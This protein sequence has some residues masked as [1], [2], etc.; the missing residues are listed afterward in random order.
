MILHVDMDAFYASIEQLDDPSLRGKAVMVGGSSNRGVVAAASYEARR[1]GVHSAMPVFQARLKCPEGVF[2]RPRMDRYKEVSRSIMRLLQQY[3]PLVEAV[4]IDEAYMDISGCEKLHG[5]AVEIGHQIKAAIQEAVGLTCSVGIAPVKFLA[6]IAS[7]MNKPDGLYVILP[8]DM[9][10]FIEALPVSKIPGVGK[11][12]RNILDRMGINTLGQVRHFPEAM[13]VRR[14][15]KFG[16]RLQQL[17]EGIDTSVVTPEHVSKS[18]SSEKTLAADTD[19]IA[20][21]KSFL[22][23]EAEE[24]ARELR[25]LDVKARTVTLKIKHSDFTLV[26]RNITL[27]APTRASEA[28]FRAAVR[29]LDQYRLN[30]KVRLIGVGASGFVS[31]ETPAQMDLFGRGEKTERDWEKVDA[32]VDTITKRFGK[33]VIRRGSLRASVPDP[34]PKDRKR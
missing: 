19:D 17:S 20:E 34:D 4:S 28:L 22:L 32:A 6:K 27:S 3:S 31:M 8:E 26:T 1:H 11:T 25:K 12:T 5:E 16:R 21:L 33:D 30:R 18:T 2:V 10:A 24:V 13:L 23:T 29:L 15:G 7:D 14:L 9:P